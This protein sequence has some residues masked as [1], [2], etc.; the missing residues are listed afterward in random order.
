MHL[1]GE[2][3][4]CVPEISNPGVVEGEPRQVQRLN[5]GAASGECVVGVGWDVPL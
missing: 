4:R 3:A 1:Y 2:A 5:G